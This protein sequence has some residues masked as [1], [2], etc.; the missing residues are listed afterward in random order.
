MSIVFCIFQ[1]FLQQQCVALTF[2]SQEEVF[3]TLTWLVMFFIFLAV[4]CVVLI[5]IDTVYLIRFSVSYCLHTI[6]HSMS[7]LFI[8]NFMLPKVP[9][10]R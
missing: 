9:K 3:I 4:N 6:P 1:M 7:L 2:D 5:L 8:T 10:L